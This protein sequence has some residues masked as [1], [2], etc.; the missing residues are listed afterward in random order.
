MLTRVRD[1]VKMEQK[2]VADV[3]KRLYLQVPV[4]KGIHKHK[5][6]RVVVFHSETSASHL[7]MTHILVDETA[8]AFYRSHGLP[9]GFPIILT[10]TELFMYGFYGKFAND[11][12]QV[13]TLHEFKGAQLMYLTLKYSGFLTMP[14]TWEG[15]DGKLYSTATSKNSI[16]NDFSEDGAR[17]YHMSVAD[18]DIIRLFRD[19]KYVAGE[20]MSYTDQM[21]GARVHKEAFVATCIGI[22]TRLRADEIY[23]GRLGK[24]VD[25]KTMH[26]TCM[27]F[28]IPVAELWTVPGAQIQNVAERL[29]ESRDFMTTTMLRSL[30]DEIDVECSKSSVNHMEILGDVLEGLVIWLIDDNGHTRAIKYK[31]ANYTSRTFGIRAALNGDIPWLSTRYK[32]HVDNYL[33]FWVV[34]PKGIDAWRRWFYTLALRA[35]HGELDGPSDERVGKHIHYADQLALHDTDAD[36]VSQFVTAVG[37]PSITTTRTVVLVLGPIGTGKSTCG[38][39]L[40][41][42]MDGCHIDGDELYPKSTIPTLSLGKERNAAT[43]TKILQALIEGK[44]PIISCGGGVLFNNGNHFVLREFLEEKLGMTMHLVVY[45][46][47]QRDAITDCYTSWD[48]TKI[49]KHRLD[50]GLWATTKAADK[51]ISEI[52]TLSQNNAKFAHTLSKMADELHC[53]TPLTPV[54]NPVTWKGNIELLKEIH[55]GPEFKTVYAA[56]VRI[57]AQVQQKSDRTG[58]FTIHYS[59]GLRAI[60]VHALSSLR[61][62]VADIILDGE[63][64]S[65][66]QCS[67]A[68]PSAQDARTL[69]DILKAHGFSKESRELHITINAGKF[70]PAT[71]REASLQLKNG[72]ETVTIP[73]KTGA[74]VSISHW[75]NR[76]ALIKMI[77]V[78]VL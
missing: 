74:S 47:C 2:D 60:D 55:R 21:H 71:M 50:T 6:I 3:L 45:L 14:L 30:L 64:L 10:G 22:Y 17:L 32:T 9:R 57:L 73:D 56:Q 40:A 51:F 19:G 33:N 49:I 77:D 63:V 31:F 38:N 34:T 62:A 52:Q 20:A 15:A 24:L 35:S 43:L 26:E 70:A 27:N 42:V 39:H 23:A 29:E 7:V 4:L 44:T 41:S 5:N 61:K 66:K 67:F 75:Q 65:T 48:V 16:G 72:D 53:F 36:A 37:L 8:E 1:F 13:G 69:V 59:N 12:R 46:P 11:R 18:E 78:L 68:R 76:E 58:H 54:L 28:N 25:H